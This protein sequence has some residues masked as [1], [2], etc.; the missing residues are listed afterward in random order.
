M[1]RRSQPESI[2][3]PVREESARR[4]SRLHAG[5][6]RVKAMIRN[7]GPRTSSNDIDSLD[8]NRRREELVEQIEKM[9]REELQTRQVDLGR[10]Q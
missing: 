10:R 4:G 8:R 7:R 1:A 9:A 5:W 6:E 3:E 2:Q